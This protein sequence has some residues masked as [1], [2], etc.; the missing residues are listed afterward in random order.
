[1][2]KISFF[3]CS[4]VWKAVLWFVLSVANTQGICCIN[5]ARNGVV[6]RRLNT[7]SSVQ[8]S[9]SVKTLPVE[10]MPV[11]S[12]PMGPTLATA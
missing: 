10:T 9:M 2:V 6:D 12:T 5:I 8:I 4:F 7:G 3:F 1:M 11:V